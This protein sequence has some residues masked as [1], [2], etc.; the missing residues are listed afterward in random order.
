MAGKELSRAAWENGK[1]QEK[2]SIFFFLY[3]GHGMC[4]FFRKLKM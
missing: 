2:E 4:S 1:G 3:F